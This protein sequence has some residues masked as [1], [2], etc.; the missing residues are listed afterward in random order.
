M[1]AKISH[2]ARAAGI[3]AVLLAMPGVAAAEWML[4]GRH[5]GC[6]A[7]PAAAK[8]LEMLQG[9]SAPGELAAKLRREGVSVKTKE[10]T[11]PGGAMIEPTA[12]ARNLAMIFVPRQLCRSLAPGKPASR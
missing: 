5:G 9:V 7:L 10:T 1:T 6:V 4:M 2:L 11:V 8:R 12:P 3:V